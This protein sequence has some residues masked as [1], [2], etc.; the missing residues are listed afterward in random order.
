MNTF[1]NSSANI[2]SDYL[3]QLLLLQNMAVL[4]AEDQ[5]IKELICE[6]LCAFPGVSDVV[7][8]SSPEPD[9]LIPESLLDLALTYQDQDFGVIRL[10][11]N[12][13]DSLAPY[14]SYLKNF[15]MMLAV[16]MSTLKDHRS[17][18][19]AQLRFFELAPDLLCIANTDGR[20]IKLSQSWSKTLGWNTEELCSRPFFEFVHPNDRDETRACLESQVIG[21]KINGFQNRYRHK[22]GEYRWLEWISHASTDENLIYA[23]ARDVTDAKTKEQALT[24]AAKVFDVA[25]DAIS[26]SD[27]NGYFL[28]VNTAFEQITGYEAAQAIGK[29]SNILKS[30]HQDESFYQKLWS[31]LIETG[32]WQGEIWNRR[33]DGEAFLCYIFITA[34]DDNQN[35]IP[36]RRYV[37]VMR[38]ITSQRA[39]EERIRNLAY[40]D[41]LTGL[42]NRTLFQD[43]LDYAISLARRQGDKVAILFLDLDRFKEVND[44][45]GHHI[46]DQFLTKVAERLEKTLRESDTVARLGG[47]E[48]VILVDRVKAIDDI[49]EI[50]QKAHDSI[51][52]SISVSGKPFLTTASLGVAIYPDDGEDKVEL[53]KNADT[54]MYA[55]KN[56]GG[57]QTKFFSPTMADVAIE[58]M[59]LETGL[60]SA[61]QHEEFTMYYQP[62][63][64]L[65]TG[66]IIG[67]EALIR[68]FSSE[69][70]FVAPD[71][72]IPI[73]EDTGLIE[74]LGRWII[75]TVLKDLA[76]MEQMPWGSVPIAINL[77]ARQFQEADLGGFIF[78]EAE[79]WGASTDLIELEVTESMVM[80]NIDQ[81]SETLKSL[82]GLGIRIAIDDFGTGHSSLAYLKKLPLDML[83]IDRNFVQDLHEDE[84][85]IAIVETIIMLAKNLGLEVV[86]EGVEKPEH[87][88]ILKTFH[89]NAA[90]GYH[91]A[92]PM[93]FSD[94]TA[95]LEAQN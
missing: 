7:F 36:E 91:Y 49:L 44:T 93:P 16:T 41:P 10:H 52:H 8:H 39:A 79:L 75:S 25:S 3:A 1:S 18:Q 66:K 47:D 70:G 56:A 84:D 54:A 95:L 11:I 60:R 61:I 76:M 26:V 32:Q 88:D 92:K 37:S 48:F 67:A 53:M 57:N 45:E 50:A 64:C 90:Q 68:W 9:D 4:L 81:A 20:F 71:R 42:A 83:K 46:G 17:A 59:K 58:R 6:G 33:K 30:N 34:V 85:D 38:D 27:E 77:S 89:C 2:R 28:S 73:A 19:T 82:R 14:I 5:Q 65:L 24:L 86:A 43:R 55:A 62:K 15:A 31:S 35:G 40:H 69:F 80:E 72:F 21:A 78:S 94:F 12:D 51:A 22:D 74:P 63:Y 13:L 23:V 29:K 87:V